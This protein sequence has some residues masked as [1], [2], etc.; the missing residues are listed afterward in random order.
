MGESCWQVR[1]SWSAYQHVQRDPL[2]AQSVDVHERRD[3]VPALGV[4]DEHFPLVRKVLAAQV[5]GAR[6]RQHLGDGRELAVTQHI[7]KFAK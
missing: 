6:Q 1:P 7:S 2:L 5:T 3:N 4:V